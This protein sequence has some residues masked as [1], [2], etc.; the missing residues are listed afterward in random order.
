MEEIKCLGISIGLSFVSKKYNFDNKDTFFNNF[1]LPNL[2]PFKICEIILAGYG[3]HD[4]H[5]II[6]KSETSEID[7]AFY[8]NDLKLKLNEF[9]KSSKKNCL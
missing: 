1:M 5:K 6:F 8:I 3:F 7:V 9:L 4:Y 2:Y